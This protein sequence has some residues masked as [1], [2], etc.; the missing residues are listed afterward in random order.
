MST[1]REY[2]FIGGPADG[3]S[4]PV[5]GSPR[6]F[7]VPSGLGAKDPESGAA[8]D[9]HR[10]LVVCSGACMAFYVTEEVAKRGV[11]EALA[12]GYKGGSK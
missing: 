5:A 6:V 3:R 8:V 11:V 7:Q 9:Y 1:P 2:M 10:R 12:A 4:L